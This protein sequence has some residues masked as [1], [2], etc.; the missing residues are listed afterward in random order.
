MTLILC[1]CHLEVLLPGAEDFDTGYSITV[2]L[3][4]FKIT[5]LYEPET[6]FLKIRIGD[7]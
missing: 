4:L 3:G 2:A 7:V 6:W 1:G 5:A